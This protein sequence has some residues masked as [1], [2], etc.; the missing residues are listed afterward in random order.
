MLDKTII[1]EKLKTV[2]DPE[3]GLDIVSLGLI[4]GV[5]ID[6]D[7]VEVLMTLTSPFCP[8]ADELIQSVEKAVGK[9]QNSGDVRVEITF[10]PPWEPP[11]EVKEALG[12][13]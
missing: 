12:L 1:T 5:K 13:E 8:F 4:R 11:Q 9:L 2:K 6:D 10:D 3:L 7:G